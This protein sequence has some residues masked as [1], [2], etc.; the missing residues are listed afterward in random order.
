L[1]KLP[2]L[3]GDGRRKDSMSTHDLNAN[4]PGYKETKVGWI[5]EDWECETLGAVFNH[6]RA[7]GSEGLA[8]YSVTVDRGLIPRSELDRKMAPDLTA[9]ESLLVEPGDFAYNMMR[10]WQGSV[11]VADTCC[12]V[13]PAYVICRPRANVSSKFMLCYFKSHPGL[14]HLWAYS[15]GITNDRLRLYFSDFSLVPAP[16]PSFLEQQKIGEILSTA[17]E[18]IAKTEEFIAAKR[19]ENQ[20]LTQE[21]LNGGRRL[22][23]FQGEWKMNRLSSMLSHVFRPVDWAPHAIFN[24]VSVR[25]KALGLF[26]RESL[27]GDEYKTKDL[28]QIHAGDFLISKRQVSHGA[29]AMVTPAFDGCHVSKEYAILANKAPELLH[30]P[31]FDWLSKT[32]RMWWHAFVASNGVVIEKLI[33]V[34]KDFL[35]ISILLP[36]TIDE[37]KAITAVLDASNQAIVAMEK[38]LAALKQQR[39]A[40]MQQLLTGHLRVKV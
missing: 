33:F 32:R 38:K 24:L 3:G 10:M 5:P 17:D 12:V 34:P 30:M 18:V 29:L 35:K 16:I 13:S 7:R 40:L 11:A 14:Y 25:R 9:G 22:P 39:G 28:H 19:R 21:L 1:E 23:G 26:R 36:P 37:Q 6:R 20:A 4:R 15:Y 8:T 27:R 2:D 31:F